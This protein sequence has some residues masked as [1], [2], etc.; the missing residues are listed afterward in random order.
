VEHFQVTVGHR[1]LR[2]RVGDA[3][4]YC[5]LLHCGWRHFDRQVHHVTLLLRLQSGLWKYSDWR[6]IPWILLLPIVLLCDV[7]RVVHGAWCMLHVAC[8][9]LNVVSCRFRNVR[10]VCVACRVVWVVR[11]KPDLT[12]KLET[13]KTRKC[14][15]S[16]SEDPQTTIR[17]PLPT[18]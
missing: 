6:W 7:R 14:R 3:V 8:C 12:T 18:R 11:S 15:K 13:Q 17:P 5:G 16:K 4:L 10:L 2:R 1:L 9:M